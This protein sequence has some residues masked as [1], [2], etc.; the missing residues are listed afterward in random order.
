MMA[1]RGFTLMEVMIA[2]TVTALVAMLAASALHAGIDVRERIQ[3][4]RTTTEAEARAT[5]WLATM[6]R[7]A[8]APNAV[9]EPLLH[10]ERQAFTTANAENSDALT[11][12]SQ[13]VEAPLGAGEIW[14]VSLAV[15]DDGLHVQA[16]PA[17]PASNRIPLETV[18]PHITAIRVEALDA[19]GGPDNSALWRHDWPLLRTMPTA[20]RLAFTLRTGDLSEPI[21]FDTAPLS[22]PAVA[23]TALADKGLLKLPGVYSRIAGAAAIASAGIGRA[24][25]V[26]ASP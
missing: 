16:V 3:R 14:R 2:L 15:H 19:H 20:L 8:P 18:L 22:A 1:R 21:V 5:A 9:D 24:K 13:G 10:I 12:L 25:P 11:F 4:H 23:L 17:N 6:L 26:G 7:H